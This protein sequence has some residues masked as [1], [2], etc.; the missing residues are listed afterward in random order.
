MLEEK[1]K[2]LEK[3]ESDLEKLLSSLEEEQVR[4]GCLHCSLSKV[5][6]ACFGKWPE[7]LRF[8]ALTWR[9]LG[10]ASECYFISKL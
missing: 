2:E 6:N 4:N 1:E 10:G 5:P 8:P 3:K 9:Q 7:T